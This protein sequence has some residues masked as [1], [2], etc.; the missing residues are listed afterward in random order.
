M[1]NNPIPDQS[2]DFVQSGMVLITDPKADKYLN[3]AQK[4]RERLTKPKES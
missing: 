3:M 2:K 1:A 4:R